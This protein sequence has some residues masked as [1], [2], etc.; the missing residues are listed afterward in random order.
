MLENGQLQVSNKNNQMK[1]VFFFLVCQ[2]TLFVQIV[3]AEKIK[4][5]PQFENENHPEIGY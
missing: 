5:V 3:S 1:K 4:H 2:I